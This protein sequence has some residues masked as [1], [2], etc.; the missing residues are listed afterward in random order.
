MLQN[1]ENFI[2]YKQ[3]YSTSINGG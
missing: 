2:N 3:S 1:L